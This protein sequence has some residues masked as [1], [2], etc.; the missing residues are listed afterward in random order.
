MGLI[1][2]KIAGLNL[3]NF[4]CFSDLD[5]DFST[6]INLFIGENGSGKTHLLKILFA[7][8]GLGYSYSALDF[9]DGNERA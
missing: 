6:G 1:I 5:V 9:L 3:K 7:H 8:Q 2:E 4:T